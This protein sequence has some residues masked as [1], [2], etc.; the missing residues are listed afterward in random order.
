LPAAL[1]RQATS[2]AARSTGA[3]LFKIA[4]VIWGAMETLTMARRSFGYF[5]FAARQFLSAMRRTAI[6]NST[7]RRH[8]RMHAR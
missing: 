5:Y 1:K 7:E 3:D 6:Q 8:A 4:I 2:L